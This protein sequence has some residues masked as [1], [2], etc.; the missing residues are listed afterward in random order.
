MGDLVLAGADAEC[1]GLRDADAE[2]GFVCPR[3]EGRR[4][5]SRRGEEF[6]SRTAFVRGILVVPAWLFEISETPTL[7]LLDPR[8]P[9][10]R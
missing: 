8:L 1:R 10:E 7:G 5:D 2:R 4:R 3:E 6:G 9:S